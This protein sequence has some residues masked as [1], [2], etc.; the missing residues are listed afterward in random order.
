M[1]VQI[2]VNAFFF[3][4]LHQRELSDTRG[5]GREA[6]EKMIRVREGKQTETRR[7]ES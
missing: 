4:E 1:W 7:G 5:G 2:F 3:L 6:K